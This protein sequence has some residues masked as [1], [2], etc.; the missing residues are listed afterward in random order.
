MKVQTIGPISNPVSSKSF[1]G[2]KRTVAYCHECDCEREIIDI[3]I[4][5]EDI[6]TTED[7]DWVRAYTRFACT[8]TSPTVLI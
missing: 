6:P 1:T 5:S 8:H 3:C 2:R 4:K 7:H